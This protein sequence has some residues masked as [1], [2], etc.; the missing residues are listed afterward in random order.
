MRG[1]L[2]T[3]GATLMALAC[4]LGLAGA[5]GAADRPDCSRPFTLALHEHG[6]L[7]SA[8]TGAGIDKDIADE[9]ARRSGCTV[10]VTLMPRARIWQLIESGGLDFSLSG[11]TNAERD[12]FAAFAWYFSNKYYLLVRK[13]AG[14][15][16]L[17]DF[18]RQPQ[19]QLGAIRS[20]RYSRTADAMVERL[21]KQGRVSHASGLAPLYEVLVLN[22]IPGH[23]RRALRRPRGR[24]RATA[25]THHHPRVR[26]S[27]G[28]ARPDHV[29]EKPERG[30]A[31]EMARIDRR[32]ARRR[33]G[34]AHLP[35]LLCGRPGGRDGE[36]LSKASGWLRQLLPVL[37]VFA[38]SLV[39]T[40]LLWQHEQTNA[41]IGR[42]FS[43][44]VH[45]REVIGRIERRMLAQE[46]LLR[47]VRGLY[48]ASDDVSR[49]DFRTYAHALQLGA[50]FAGIEGL[51]RL[52][53]V[54]AGGKAAHE[55][56]MRSQGFADYAIQP[57][58]ERERYAPLVQLEPSVPRNRQGH[59]FDGY[60]DPARRLALD[61]A[62]DSG[63]PVLTGPA[64]TAR[65]VRQRRA[66]GVSRC[67][68]RCT[69]KARPRPRCRSGG[70]I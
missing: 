62:R 11:I 70:G 10:Q 46:Q 32:D 14:V 59:G 24:Q 25:R 44:D 35:Q 19:L 34:A 43:A 39:A 55:Q 22:R 47:G 18:E 52:L 48:S 23:D 36:F 49:E 17:A 21:Q 63:E 53:L 58:G 45:L 26:R 6:L 64:A 4:T 51:G 1:W 31:A 33:H 9:L 8:A 30:R 15:R 12:R 5:A 28:T 40:F 56:E 42:R 29:E 41:E 37:G 61:K 13:D 57:T 7:Y 60:S 66:G 68:S 16:Q 50:D 3:F 54:D 38:A 67:T 65:R 27:A 20:F 2:G 69:G